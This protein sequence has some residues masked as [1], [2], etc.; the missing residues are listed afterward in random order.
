MTSEYNGCLF[1]GV[2]AAVSAVPVIVCGSGVDIGDM[3]VEHSESEEEEGEKEL[4]GI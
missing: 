1:N 2:E 4:R 3:V